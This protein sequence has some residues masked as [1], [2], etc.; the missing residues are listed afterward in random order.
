MTDLDWR[1]VPIE[2]WPGEQTEERQSHR[3]RTSKS[4]TWTRYDGTTAYGKRSDHGVDWDKT[5]RLLQ[6]ELA[7]LEAEN[8]LLQMA[9]TSR[10]I[11][12]DGWIR[13]NAR[14]EHPGVILTFDS[15]H[16]PLSY[17]CDTFDDW[18]ANVRGIA[19]ALEALRMVDRYGVTK[20]GEQYR[21]WGQLPPAGGTT[22]TMTARVAA[23]ILVDVAGYEGEDEEDVEKVLTDAESLQ[24]FFRMAA[25]NAHPD[26]GGDTQK[27]QT[28]NEAKRVLDRHHGRTGK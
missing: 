22:A 20:R 4:V 8:I 24:W 1:V 9:V 18:Q 26:V 2:R 14:P 21:G 19:K 23:E 28:V 27:F 6:R 25:K 3:F 11:R 17:P 5:T 7:H 12:N 16:G 15:K 10:D 13:A